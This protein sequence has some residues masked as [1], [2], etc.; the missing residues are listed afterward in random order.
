MS[1]A[2]PKRSRKVLW[3]MLALTVAPVAA[4]YLIFYFWPPSRTVN[5]GELIAPRRLPDARL[6]LADGTPFRLSRLRGK[7][8]LVT[9]D[10]GA[11]NASCE[12]KLYYM[13]QVRRAQG[14]EM[15]RVERA[16]LINDGAAMA[17]DRMAPYAGTWMIRAA[18]TAVLG[19]FPAQGSRSAHIYLVDPLGNLMMRYPPDPDPRRMIRDLQ[20]LL[21]AS[22][23]G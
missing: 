21:K 3:V 2:P 13:R 14:K 23:I 17:P 19:L 4:S 10:S 18:G 9:V 20:R 8:V 6:A 15:E 5:Y 7:W 1:D 11:C 12:K 16:F 22:R